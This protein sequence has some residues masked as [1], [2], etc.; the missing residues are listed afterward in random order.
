[1]KLAEIWRY[2][3]KSMAGERLAAAAMRLDGIESDRGVQVWDERNRILTARNHP[4][5][6]RPSGIARRRWRAAG[7]RA[8]LDRS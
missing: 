5:P 4:A 6:A 2:P 3:V 1:M 8:A 7:R